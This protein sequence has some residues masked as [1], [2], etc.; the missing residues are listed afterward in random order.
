[1]LK[2]SIPSFAVSFSHLEGVSVSAEQ[3]TRGASV[4]IQWLGICLPMQGT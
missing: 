1:M 4:V 2:G 3:F